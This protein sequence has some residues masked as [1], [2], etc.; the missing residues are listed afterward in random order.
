MP[1]SRTAQYVALYRALETVETSREPLFR[2]P[3]AELFLSRTLL[4]AVR[5]SR[6]PALAGLLRRYA[7]RRAPGARSSAI[8]RTRFID[9]LVRRAAAKGVRQLVLLGAGYDCRAHRLPELSGTRVFEVDREEIQRRKRGRLEASRDLLSRRDVGYVPVDFAKD[10][11]AAALTTAGWESTLP[12]TFVWEGVTNYLTEPDVAKV[13]A[14]VGRSAP[15]TRLVFTYIHRGVIDGTAR[16]EGADA[17]VSNVKRLGEPWTFGLHPD[18]LAAFVGRFGLE[19]EENI[20]AD[21]YRQ[22]YL[23]E[24]PAGLRGYAFYRIAVARVA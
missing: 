7:D 22:R 9:D 3:F 16:F 18:E 5:L 20:G 12:S 2:D 17:L 8:G 10:D 23:A 14:F 15:G 24:G 21:A 6:I 11:L 19:L 13:L 4:S 1:A